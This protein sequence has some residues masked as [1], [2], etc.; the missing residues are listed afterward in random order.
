MFQSTLLKRDQDLE[1]TTD[2]A[3]DYQVSGDGLHWTVQLREDVVFSDG[4][5][6]TAEDVS[7]TYETAMQAQSVVDLSNLKKIEVKSEDEVVFHL[8][9]PQS[10]FIT[11]LL[12]LGIVPK[13]AYGNDYAENPIGTGPY[14]MVEWRKGEQLIVEKKSK[15]LWGRTRV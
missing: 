5:E 11:T 6:L 13:H 4:E 1:I 3:K 9:K 7:F 2:L 8:E 15:L 10:T 12:T 14:Q